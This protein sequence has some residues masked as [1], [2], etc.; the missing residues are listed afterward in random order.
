[1]RPTIKDVAKKAQVSTAT[2]SLV[3]GGHPRISPQTIRKVIESKTPQGRKRLVE[4]AE[5]PSFHDLKKSLGKP[6]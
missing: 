3:M 6:G 4:D 2:V 1:M 5:V